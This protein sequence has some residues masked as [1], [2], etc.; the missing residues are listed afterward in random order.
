[1]RVV[2]KIAV[3]VATAAITIGAGIGPALADPPSGT[4]PKLTDVVGVGSDTTQLVMDAIAK[5]YDGTSPAHKLYS[6]DAVN[7]STGATGDTI[8]TKGSSSSDTTCS[9]ARPNGSSA[10]IKAL[11]ATIK[12]G[13]SPCIDFARASRGTQTGDPTGLLWVGWGKDAVSWTTPKSGS[14]KPTTLTVAQLTAIYTCTSTTWKQVG[15][16]STATIVPVLPQTSSGTRAFFLKQI[17]VTTPGSCVVNGSI[18][19]TGDTHNPVPIEENTGV[20]VSDS[21]GPLTG[22]Q[23]EFTNNPNA[24][25]PYSVAVWIGQTPK[26]H[27][28]GHATSSSAPGVLNQPQK[29]SGVSP[30]STHSTTI[31]TLNTK[32]TSTLTRVVWNVVPNAGTTTAPKIPASLLPF[33]GPKG[34][35][36]SDTADQKS[37]GFLP[38]S[39]SLCGTLFQAS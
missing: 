6:W 33:F 36:C 10:G 3:V 28:G 27:G 11:A 23:F 39:G 31:D 26:P 20:S 32:F 29:V 8:V 18:N 15:G 38:L 34:A 5:H 14:G 16:T 19:I 12:D 7:P 17:G 22:N 25:F 24:I 35:V 9:M 37:Y 21:G 30:V 2:S 13:A 1:M 4:L